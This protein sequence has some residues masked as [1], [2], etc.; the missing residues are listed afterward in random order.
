MHELD[1]RHTLKYD[2]HTQKQ[3]SV[4][5]DMDKGHTEKWQTHS[6]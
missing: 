4:T 3:G 1:K 5:I 6:K 2:K